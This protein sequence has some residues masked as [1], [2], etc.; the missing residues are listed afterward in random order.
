MTQHRIRW[1]L[2]LGI[3]AMAIHGSGCASSAVDDRYDQS[4]PALTGVDAGLPNAQEHHSNGD[5]GTCGTIVSGSESTTTF[6]TTV[7][8]DNDGT[9][10]G[11][12]WEHGY[13]SCPTNPLML[14]ETATENNSTETLRNVVKV[15]QGTEQI[16]LVTASSAGGTSSVQ[17]DYG[18]AFHGTH[19]ANIVDD[20]HTITGEVDGRAIVPAA[21][22]PPG[23]PVPPIRFADHEHVA[24]DFVA[25][26][27][28][29][30]IIGRRS[31]LPR[32]SR[33]GYLLSG[34]I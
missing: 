10:H 27:K 32:G 28:R 13:E 31:R 20:G 3:A 30:G 12:G 26:K 4:A 23:A 1:V 14:V 16:L 15:S 34:P 33:Y 5:H 29:Y 7:A 2:G 24:R 8:C 18:S 21:S 17:I 19:E 25:H 9:P 11:R 22:P 6:S